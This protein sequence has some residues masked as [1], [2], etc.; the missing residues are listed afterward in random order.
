MHAATST[1]RR[2]V[3]IGWGL[4]TTAACVVAVACFAV[5]GLGPHTGTYRT[6]SVLSGSMTPTFRPGDVVIDTPISGR[7]LRVGDVITYST[8]VGEHEVV[9][10]RVVEIVQRGAHPTFRTKGDANPGADPWTAHTTGSTLWRQRAV[11]PH[12]GTVIGVVRRSASSRWVTLGALGLIVLLGVRA[13]W[14]T[15]DTE[16]GSGDRAAKSGSDAEPARPE[17]PVAA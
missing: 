9:S 16:P 2:A 1:I 3:A 14:R 11:V 4:L 12:A 8:P 10:H 17:A 13:I 6:L 5:F 7:D 15:E